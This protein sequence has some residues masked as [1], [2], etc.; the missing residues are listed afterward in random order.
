MKRWSLILGAAAL[1]FASLA[2]ACYA[3]QQMGIGIGE[4]R[5]K[6][7]VVKM[8]VGAC[9]RGEVLFVDETGMTYICRAGLV[10]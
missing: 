10:L 2:A 1:W 6:G 4:I 5:G 8:V 7:R 3:G 9:K